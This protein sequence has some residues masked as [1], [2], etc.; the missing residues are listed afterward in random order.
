MRTGSDNIELNKL[1]KDLKKK[2]KETNV[3]IW[4]ELAKR[5]EKSSR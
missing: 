2:S 1:I 5:L 3:E 4:R